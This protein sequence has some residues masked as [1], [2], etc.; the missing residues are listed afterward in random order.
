[1]KKYLKINFQINLCPTKNNKI[2]IIKLYAF[3]GDLNNL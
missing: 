2:I 3:N 1:M